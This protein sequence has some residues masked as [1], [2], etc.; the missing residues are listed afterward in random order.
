MFPRA[1]QLI[2]GQPLYRTV[3]DEP[4]LVDQNTVNPMI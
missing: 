1:N 4:S 3:E 2:S